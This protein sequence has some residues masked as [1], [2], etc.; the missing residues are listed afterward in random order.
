[1]GSVRRE[2]RHRL[3][4]ILAEGAADGTESAAR[5]A[6]V[7]PADVDMQLPARIGDYTDF[8]CSIHHATNVGSMLRPEDPLFPNFKHLPIGY[9]GRASS[10]VASETPVRRPRG[11]RL[12]PGAETPEFGPSRLLDYEMEVGAFV[13]PG[14]SLG[15]PI[16]IERAGD[17]LVGLCLVNDWSARDVQVWEYKPLGPFLGKSFATTVSPWV[18][19]AE[20]LAP[21]HCPAPPRPDGDPE[22]LPYLQSDANASS[23]GIDV[24]VEVWLRSERMRAGGVEAVRLSQGSLRDLYWTFGQMIAHHTSNGCNL[25]PG[26]LI[27]SGTVSGADRDARG[28]LLELT[29]RGSE[30]ID[31][32]GGEQRLFLEDGDE[33]TLRGFC[34][35]DGRARIGFGECRGRVVPA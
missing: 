12:A 5:G 4:E 11:Q 10:V 35:R 33:V 6:L 14:N 17:H 22:P 32:P 13:G 34:E 31:L 8:Y 15:D 25:H 2:L 16:P 29:W 20:A 26:D 18:V 27:A 1:M 28:C 19:T 9:H 24:T 21:F 3:A 30:P 23:G 7:D